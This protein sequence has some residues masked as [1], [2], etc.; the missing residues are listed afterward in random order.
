MHIKHDGE[1]KILKK[2]LR[3]TRAEVVQLTDEV[4]KVQVASSEYSGKWPSLHQIPDMCSLTNMGLL[5]FSN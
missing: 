1:I 5:F 3:H 2:Q 4:R